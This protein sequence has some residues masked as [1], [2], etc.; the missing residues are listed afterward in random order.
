MTNN[1]RTIALNGLWH[2]NPAL[3]QLLGLCPLLAVSNSLVNGLGMG[4]ATMA[5]LMSSNL[6]IALTRRWIPSEIRIPV[7]VLL[8]A[9]LVSCVELLMQAFT[10]GL[11]LNLGIFVALI[12]T[13]CIIIGRAEAFASKNPVVDGVVDGLMMGGGFAIV[14]TL[15]GA[16]RELIGQGTLFD[17]AALL[18]G[19]IASNW[20]LHIGAGGEHFLLAIL[21]PGAFIGLGLL[22]ALKNAIDAGLKARAQPV[23]VAK[24]V[25]A[26]VT[27]VSGGS[28]GE[29]EPA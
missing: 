6:I 8:I 10:P 18:F 15:L 7:F 21:A 4:L 5:V 19:P 12:V 13:N 9:S 17:G 16:L 3:V 2:S 29:R 27:T 1:W 14:L 26:R 23:A 20:T 24:P 28:E 25:R 11:Y 22:V